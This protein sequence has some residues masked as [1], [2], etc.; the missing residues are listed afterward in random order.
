MDAPGVRV[1]ML[2]PIVSEEYQVA[3][4]AYGA[5]GSVA[6]E[7][8]DEELIPAIQAVTSRGGSS[9]GSAG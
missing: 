2:L 9:L 5:A 6:K 1:I 7:R 4:R 8:L 3:A